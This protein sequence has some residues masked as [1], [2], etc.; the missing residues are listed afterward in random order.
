MANFVFK[1]GVVASLAKGALTSRVA[2]AF[3]IAVAGGMALILFW[4]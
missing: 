4:P 2:G 3:G 1:L